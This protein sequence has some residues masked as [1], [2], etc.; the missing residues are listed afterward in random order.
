VQPVYLFQMRRVTV[1]CS[2]LPALSSAGLFGQHAVDPAQ[3]YHRLIC[4]VH[5]TG[6]G[7]NGD[8]VIPE[9]APVS[10][11]PTATTASPA[12]AASAGQSVAR[13]TTGSTAAVGA[14]LTG[15]AA[16]SS[17]ITDDGK[18][19]I[20]H[21]VAVDR[22]SFAAIFADTRP[23]IKVFEIG[24]DKQAD[25]EAFLQQYKKGFTLDSIRVVAR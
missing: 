17:Q 16:W 19:A 12:G 8:P 22:N 23:E 4:L 9:Y 1:I 20:I 3:R 21:I 6:S 10:A 5:L 11:G 24:K 7:K 25:I 18:M 2:L 15:I 13:A 14:P